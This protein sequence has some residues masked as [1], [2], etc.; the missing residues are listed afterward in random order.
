MAKRAIVLVSGGMDSAVVLAW[1]KRE[2]FECIA[3]S[4]DYGQRHRI[5][6]EC[7][8]RVAVKCGVTE[9]LVQKMDLRAVGASALTADIAVPKD[10]E[11]ALSHGEI[12]IT[13]VPAR[14]TLFLSY[15]LALAES[16]GASDIALGVNAVDYSGYPDCRP[17]FLAAFTRL[18]NLATRAG[19]EA[20]AAGESA[21]HIHAPLVALSKCEIVKL[22]AELGVDFAMTISCY[23][24]TSAGAPCRRC[25]ACHL[26]AL[27]FAQAQ[28][29][30]AGQS[31]TAR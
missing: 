6:L 30:D 15:A 21:F 23:D 17:E 14:N 28:L 19:V 22:G 1:M 7:A 24:P 11:G 18:A 31:A 16:R 8:R 2:G 27:G 26:R 13:Y 25:D 29:L 4:F 9:H 10:R 5:E 12:P 3:L 20:T